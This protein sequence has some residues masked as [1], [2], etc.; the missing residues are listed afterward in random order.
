MIKINKKLSFFNKKSKADVIDN[1]I[2][3]KL[4]FYIPKTYSFTV[5]QWNNQK[6][7]IIKNINRIF[8]SKKNIVIRSSSINEDSL[9]SSNAGKFLSLL[10][11][12]M[13]DKKIMMSINLVIKSYKK[14]KKNE[15]QVFIQEMIS[16]VS[17]SGVL[18]TKD[19]DTGLNYYVINYDDITGKTDTVTSGYG[20]HSNRT[21]FIFKKFGENIKSPRFK[22]LINCVIDLEKTIGN[23]DI[24]IEFAITKNLK[25]Y[26]FQVRPI[27]T[28]KK[29]KKVSIKKHE[30]YLLSAEKKLKKIF[31]KPKNILGKNTVFGQ[32]PD[33]N[34]V[35]MLGKYPSELSYSLYSK[36]ITDNTWAKSRAIMGYRNMSKHPLMHQICG[37]PYIDTRLSLNSF[38]PQKLSTIIGKKIID[39]G[40]EELK[41]KPQ[42]HD[43]VEFELSTPS[44]IFDIKKK[45]SKRFKN[46]LSKNETKTFIKE[47]RL[48]TLSF[49]DEEKEYSLSKV[50][51]QI[52]YLNKIFSNFNNK[53]INQIPRL[54]F[55]CKNHGTLNFSILARHGFV[56]KSFLNSLA[57]EKVISNDQVEKFEQNLNTITKRMLNDLNLV[58]KNI[59]SPKK[60]MAEYGHL[61]PGTYDITS[62]RYDQIKNFYFK[63]DKKKIKKNKLTLSDKQKKIINKLLEKN[64]FKNIDSKKLFDYIGD[65]ISLREY[66]KFIF[67][68]YLS[69]I[70][71]IIANYGAK[72]N[73]KRN[74]LTNLNIN[75][76]LNKNSYKN[77]IKLKM[78][79]KRNKI[80][81]EK[82]QI[83][84]L[85]LL[86]Q[87]ISRTRIIPYQVS[88]PNFIT[89]KK[90]QGQKL[91]NP[92]IKKIKEL[93]NKIILIENADPGYDWIFSAN[94]LALV[95]RYGGINSHMSIRCA[96]LGIPAAIGCGDQ[97]FSELLKKKSIYLDCSS[98][99]IY[100][101]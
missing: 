3:K 46:K 34:P 41:K 97:I 94:I 12:P 33:W 73:L 30:K 11:I 47:L 32:M 4:K 56:A 21:L 74:E 38:L 24:D 75:N 27:T 63:I 58:Q 60:F 35:E 2:N 37:Q 10:N 72:N 99:A 89:Q 96:E 13:I 93:S 76:F 67:T 57:S 81:Y 68:K 18:F 9:N 71:E 50:F 87:D 92:D 64:E 22:K 42:L 84:K 78:L 82:N 23:N 79:A 85:P 69:L 1:L 49:L 44:Y 65:S 90:V 28:I 26:L 19:V 77:I 36:L 83:V 54:I 55:L 5:G 39:F 52:E 17:V 20:A 66:S 62:K 40:I 8:K 15:D 31:K 29:W 7:L 86:I 48:L 6:K 45:I 61:R 59:I 70:L 95:T 53:D 98:S 80:K 25:P 100:S 16:N 43:K 91:F 101:I 88:S 14:E 51:N